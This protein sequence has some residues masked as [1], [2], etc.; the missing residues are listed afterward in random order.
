MSLAPIATTVQPWWSFILG[1]LI[2][3]AIMLLVLIFTIRAQASQNKKLM[4]HQQSQ[5]EDQLAQQQTQFENQLAANEQLVARQMDLERE[6]AAH[7][8]ILR[9]RTSVLRAFLKIQ[10]IVMSGKGHDQLTSL[11]YDI[12]SS[13]REIKSHLTTDV[14]DEY[15]DLS[16]MYDKV[17]LLLQAQVPQI[18]EAPRPVRRRMNEELA[19]LMGTHEEW[20]EAYIDHDDQERGRIYELV[21]KSLASLEKMV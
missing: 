11:Q 4:E 21:Q 6:A 7:R 1:D 13:N 19:K 14:R 10:E 9:L 15:Q 17:T 5:V 2:T 12:L 8:E 20:V 18:S 3:G 16:N